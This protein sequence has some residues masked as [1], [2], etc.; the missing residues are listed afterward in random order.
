MVLT[1][2][3]FNILIFPFLIHPLRIGLTILYCTI[4]IAT[5]TGL[6]VGLFWLSYSLVLVVLGGLLVIFIY[7]SLLSS[8]EIFKIRGS[9]L[10]IY[11][12]ACGLITSCLRY[13]LE[14]FEFSVNWG[15]L[16][17]QQNVLNYD[18]LKV[19]YSREVWL[20]TLFLI[21]YLLV[22]LIAVVHITRS[23]R[24]ALRATRS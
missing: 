19:L 24:L 3:V 14:Y 12:L 5:L 23:E 10:F 21:F 8:N 7:V 17:S 2:L 18:Q 4:C 16:L 22:T 13:F 6:Q 15:N 9:N 20:F 11:L 1:T